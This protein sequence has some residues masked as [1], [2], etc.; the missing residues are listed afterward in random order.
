[1]ARLAL[2]LL[3]VLFAASA[4]AQSA[5]VAG[6]IGADVSRVSHTDANFYSSSPDGSETLSGSVRV[7]TA[8]GPSWGVE[9]EFVQSGHSHDQLTPVVSPLA[10]STSTTPA[11]V[12]TVPGVSF[13]FTSASTNVIPVRF[14]QSDIRQS[15]SDLDALVW[16]RQAVG[17]SV[18]LVYL[19]GVA[20]SR[21]RTEVT[22]NFPTILQLFAPLPPNSAFRSTT[23]TYGTRP[24]AGVEAR[25]GFTSHVRLIPGVRLQGIADGWLLRPYVG[26]GW[27]F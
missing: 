5:Y 18:D 13:T 26:L 6:T 10:T 9:L 24:L 12:I 17:G 8:I 19:G 16:A 22:Q 1:V 7:G 14:V 21:Q 15:H 25:I 20:F 3:V 23:I 27:F 4:G 11:Q 2:T